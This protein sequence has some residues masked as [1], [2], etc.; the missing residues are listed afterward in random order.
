MSVQSED[1]ERRA[2]I[3]S[4]AEAALERAAAGDTRASVRLVSVDVPPVLLPSS[5][6]ADGG[7]GAGG[8]I[9]ARCGGARR[10]VA[11]AVQAGGAFIADPFAAGHSGWV[12]LIAAAGV[13]VI[14]TASGTNNDPT[15]RAWDAASGAQLQVYSGH[16][17]GLTAM[18]VNAGLVLITAASDRSVRI[19]DIATGR[20][21]RALRG[22]PD[23]VVH[24]ALHAGI[25]YVA[26]GMSSPMLWVWRLATP[27]AEPIKLFGHNSGVCWVDVHMASA[28]LI[29]ASR[30]GIML[31]SPLATM[32]V[33]GVLAAGDRVTCATIGGDALFAGVANGGLR[34][35]DIMR[36]GLP[37]TFTGHTGSVCCLAYDAGVLYSGGGTHDGRVIAWDATTGTMR[38]QFPHG[39]AV[40]AIALTKH[41]M[42][43]A[44]RDVVHVWNRRSG[45]KL[46]E[47]RAHEGWVS[48]LLVGVGGARMYSG[49][50]DGGVFAWELAD[51]A[52]APVVGVAAQ[53]RT[54][55]LQEVVVPVVGLLAGATQWLSLVLLP[56]FGWAGRARDPPSA[57]AVVFVAWDWLGAPSDMTSLSSGAFVRV[58][59]LLVCLAVALALRQR[60]RGAALSR[61][62]A[63][64]AARGA[65][66]GG[67][68]GMSAAAAARLRGDTSVMLALPF[69]RADTRARGGTA[70]AAAGALVW[71]LC[72]AGCLPLVRLLAY[73]VAC[74]VVD[75][76]DPACWRSGGGAAVT[77]AAVSGVLLLLFLAAAVYLSGLE[78]PFTRWRAG[79]AFVPPHAPLSRGVRAAA[80]FSRLEAAL[81]LAVAALAAF[82]PAVP[83]RTLAVALATSLAALLALAVA[84]PVYVSPAGRA[85]HRLLFAALATAA[86]CALAAT[87]TTA[88]PRGAAAD[89][90]F[91][92]HVATMVLVWLP[93]VPAGIWA[94]AY[95]ARRASAACG[96]LCREKERSS[97]LKDGWNAWLDEE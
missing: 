4:P 91:P 29:T 14:I 69:A 57:L 28:T 70:A 30:D 27:S 76:D 47:L 86:G 24:M 59:A 77:A 3:V 78:R 23:P 41:C 20:Q 92:A 1:S 53:F 90:L 74:G 11:G 60:L 10:A 89:V 35:W 9:S 97:D 49:G 39:S 17:A 16:T 13:G 85:L 58:A 71:A 43:A 32:E 80:R 15:A 12:T 48:A 51:D 73:P 95:V 50:H 84:R 55:A 96:E 19:F 79:G 81:R 66:G 18:L 88:G 26:G 8:R 5:P 40:L 72:T 87:A 36:P 7:G 45:E 46:R 34:G 22:H 31:M 94:L 63:I 21:I 62:Q 37:R 2:L 93:A 65:E 25:L 82:S 61:D 64:D 56:A 44:S 42:C 67:T 83:P 6:R 75:A 54:P 38:T 52:R 68:G 33:S